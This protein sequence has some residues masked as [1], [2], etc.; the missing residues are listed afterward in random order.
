VQN[1]AHLTIPEIMT[2]RYGAARVATVEPLKSLVAAGIPLALGG[3]GPLNPFLNMMFAITHPNNPPEAL[4]REQ[5]MTAY[6]VGSAFAEFAE[7]DKG[8]LAAGMLA[9]VAVL[10]QDIFTA[11]TNKLPATAAAITIVNGRIVRDTLTQ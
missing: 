4:T 9:D 1:P 6:T 11:E 7:R 2:A 3:D 10:T 8:R 5:V